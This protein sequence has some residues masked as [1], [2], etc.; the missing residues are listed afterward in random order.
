[1]TCV[2]NVSPNSLWQEPTGSAVMT[3]S[4][5]HSLVCQMDVLTHLKLELWIPDACGCTEELGLA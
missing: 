4:L 1:M 5:F 2:H 3:P